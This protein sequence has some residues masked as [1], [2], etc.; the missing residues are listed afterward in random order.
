MYQVEEAKRKRDSQT[1]SSEE[2]TEFKEKI[3]SRYVSD[4]KISCLPVTYNLQAFFAVCRDLHICCCEE[5]W[6]PVVGTTKRG[7]QPLQ[8]QGYGMMV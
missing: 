3:S 2:Q 1:W 4:E 5:P 7:N 8:V 6:V